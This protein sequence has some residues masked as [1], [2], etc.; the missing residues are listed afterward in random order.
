M[1]NLLLKLLSMLWGEGVKKHPKTTMLLVVCAILA[2][3]M[4]LRITA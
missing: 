2:I 4:F 1:E 3:V